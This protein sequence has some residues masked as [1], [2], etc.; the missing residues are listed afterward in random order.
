MLVLILL[1]PLLQEPKNDPIGEES[2]RCAKGVEEV[3]ENL[4]LLKVE[5]KVVVPIKEDEAVKKVD[6]LK[7]VLKELKGIKEAPYVPVKEV[8]PKGP[9]EKK[10]KK[11]SEPYAGYFCDELFQKK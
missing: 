10:P 2:L 9:I 8:E 5:A 7:E 1:L 11:G 6:V 3:E 4:A